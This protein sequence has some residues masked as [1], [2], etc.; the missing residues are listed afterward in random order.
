MSRVL[1]WW[2]SIVTLF[3]MSSLPNKLYT[4]GQWKIISH[5]DRYHF[6]IAYLCR[7]YPQICIHK[8]FDKIK[9]LISVLCWYDIFLLPNKSSLAIGDQ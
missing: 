1:L 8:M 5:L 2:I 6:V 4:I 7:L 9:N 3:Y